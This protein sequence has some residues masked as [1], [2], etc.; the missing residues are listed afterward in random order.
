MCLRTLVPENVALLTSA[1]VLS[2]EQKFSELTRVNLMQES[3]LKFIYN[4]LTPETEHVRRESWEDSENPKSRHTFR[5]DI[6]FLLEE[7][8]RLNESTWWKDA[9]TRSSSICRVAFCVNYS[10]ASTI[11]TSIIQT[12]N[13]PI[14]RRKK[15]YYVLSNYWLLYWNI[16]KPVKALPE[17]IIECR[18][19]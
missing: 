2:S 5:K 12:V 16:T 14:H 10:T 15:S 8:R 18:L 17:F 13:Y 1:R 6:P 3:S 9:Q 19:S 7:K 11:R 4:R